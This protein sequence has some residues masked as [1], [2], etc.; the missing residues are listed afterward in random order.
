VTT[1]STT[2]AI[3]RAEVHALRTWCGILSSRRPPARGRHHVSTGKCRGLLRTR[4]EVGSGFEHVSGARRVGLRN[5][6]QGRSSSGQVLEPGG[7][8]GGLGGWA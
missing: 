2:T 1:R 4:P 8:Q 5:P 3:H 6:E 7:S